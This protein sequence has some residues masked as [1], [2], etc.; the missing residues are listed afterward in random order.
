MVSHR[1]LAIA[2]SLALASTWTSGALAAKYVWVDWT[3]ANAAGGT[4]EGTVKLQ[5]G[6]TMTV[7]FAAIKSDGSPSSFFGAQTDGTGPNYWTNSATPPTTFHSATVENEP[8]STDILQLSGGDDT[9]YVVTLS[10]P[11]VNPLMAIISLGN[12]GVTA[13]YNF[14]KDFSI[15]SQGPSVFPGGDDKSLVKSGNILSGHEGAGVIEFKGTFDKF[16]WTVPRGETW[17]GFT[18]GF[19]T[20]AAIYEAEK[21][22]GTPPPTPPVDAATS[23][24]APSKVEPPAAPPSIE[25]GSL[26]GG[27]GCSFAGERAS[28]IAPLAGLL[29]G[30]L[31]LL[32]RRSSRR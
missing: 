6:S 1:A 12:S 7:K 24:A 25:N 31:F 5:N 30:A 16:Q 10:E 32:K 14:D 13:T 20:T 22:A 19:Y 18:F 21:D 3:A 28:G 17:H 4:A 11:I 2:F 27:G 8:P 29:F 15:L 9:R 26:E 23:D